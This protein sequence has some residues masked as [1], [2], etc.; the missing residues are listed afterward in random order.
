M[1]LSVYQSYDD[2]TRS[3]FKYFD[4]RFNLNY[5]GAFYASFSTRPNARLIYRDTFG[6]PLLRQNLNASRQF[7]DNTATIPVSMYEQ[8]NLIGY[9]SYRK[10]QSV[11]VLLQLNKANCSQIYLKISQ[12]IVKPTFSSHTSYYKLI[13]F[14]FAN[15]YNSISEQPIIR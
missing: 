15:G 3:Q 2:S 6:Y 7:T 5:R 13:I 9:R 12:W 1:K 14:F 11:C 10:P 4:E 8:W